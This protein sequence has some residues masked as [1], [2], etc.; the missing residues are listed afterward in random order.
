M[1]ASPTARTL[2]RCRK[3]G[4]RAHVVEKWIPQTHRR[5][6]LFGFIDVLALDGEDGCLGIQATST[7]NVSSRL[8]KSFTETREALIDWLR[9]GNRFE[10]WGWATRGPAGKRKLWTL[11]QVGVILDGDD[12]IRAD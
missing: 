5:I 12:L 11:K 10:V 6:D 7:S 3:E 1:T 2:Q 4:W 8:H 9:H